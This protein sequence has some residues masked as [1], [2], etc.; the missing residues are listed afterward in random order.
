MHTLSL[1]SLPFSPMTVEEFEAEV[2]KMY[3]G[4]D[5]MLQYQTVISLIK[6]WSKINRK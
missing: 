3:R 2:E 6:I 4:T 1:R 5:Y